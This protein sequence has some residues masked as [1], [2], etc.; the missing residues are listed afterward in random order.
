M[1]MKKIITLLLIVAATISCQNDDDLKIIKNDNFLVSKVFDNENQLLAE[2]IYNDKNQLVKRK[3]TDPSS[4]NSSELV[5]SY[6]ADLLEKIAYIDNDNPGF[7]NEKHFGY[8]NSG[9]MDWFETHQNGTV[10]S[11]INIKYNENGTVKFLYTD[12]SNPLI[13][14][15]YDKDLNI[16]KTISPLVDPDSNKKHKEILTFSYDKK[17]KPYFGFKQL[18]PIDLLPKMGGAQIW[19]RSFSKNN[20]TANNTSGTTWTYKYD[21]NGLPI[22][23]ETKWKDI[24]TEKPMVIK[25]TYKEKIKL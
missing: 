1:N 2:Y 19:E 9:K 11:H 15:E 13:S 23:I 7:N 22:A 25:I 18:V 8:D 10:L 5:F 6:S 24:G 20:M 21:T 14:F 3:F 17:E 12:D 16:T 4:K